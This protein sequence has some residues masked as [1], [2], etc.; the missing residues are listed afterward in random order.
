MAGTA[1]LS[2]DAKGRCRGAIASAAIVGFAAVLILS[3]HRST[4]PSRGHAPAIAAC[5]SSITW[6]VALPGAAADVAQA[7]HTALNGTFWVGVLSLASGV[8]VVQLARLLRTVRIGSR[9]GH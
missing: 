5:H 3:V 9:C 7:T 6:T 2:M 1:R 4:T 8:A